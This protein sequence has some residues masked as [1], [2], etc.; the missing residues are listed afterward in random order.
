MTMRSNAEVINALRTAPEQWLDAAIIV[1]EDRF[2]FVPEDHPQRVPWVIAKRRNHGPP[3]LRLL[4][5][6]VRVLSTLGPRCLASYRIL[7][8]QTDFYL[9]TTSL[10][11]DLY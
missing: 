1:F 7:P 2:E 10:G 5:D 11:G 6:A 9:H 8:H 3:D 4:D